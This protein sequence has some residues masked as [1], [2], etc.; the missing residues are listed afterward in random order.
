MEKLDNTLS[1]RGELR[2]WHKDLIHALPSQR[3]IFQW[4]DCCA[5]ARNIATIG[6]PN[7]I[8]V[9]KIMDYPIA[10]FYNYSNLVLEEMYNRGFSTTITAKKKFDEFVEK[11]DTNYKDYVSYEELFYNW[12]NDKY[13]WQCL[14]NLEE[15]YDC[16]GIT[17]EEMKAIDDIAVFYI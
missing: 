12:H 9:N 4:Q 2:L 1:Q 15:K 14:Y 16:G 6:I 11:I 5:I 10:H 8:L 13:F 17:E 7:H 3:L